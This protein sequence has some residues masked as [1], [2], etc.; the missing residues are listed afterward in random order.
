MTASWCPQ[1]TG[2]QVRSCGTAQHHV[3]PGKNFCG[4]SRQGV[5]AVTA[6]RLIRSD[7]VGTPL[8][9]AEKAQVRPLGTGCLAFCNGT[10]PEA[11]YQA[12]FARLLGDDPRGFTCLGADR[13]GRLIGWTHHLSQRHARKVE[14]GIYRRIS[15]VSPTCAA[16]V[17]TA[18]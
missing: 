6:R 11:A 10:V 14:E 5:G 7:F 17:R 1:E 13:E 12:T 8:Y 3:R 2:E 16:R 15:T 9:I 4:T 18:R